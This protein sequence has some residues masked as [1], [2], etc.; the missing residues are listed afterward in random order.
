MKIAINK[1]TIQGKRNVRLWKKKALNT[2]HL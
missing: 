2:A 1:H